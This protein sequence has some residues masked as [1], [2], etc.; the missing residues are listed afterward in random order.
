[1][2]LLLTLVILILSIGI[3]SANEDIGLDSL[4]DNSDIIPGLI[5]PDLD[6]DSNDDGIISPN[7]DSGKNNAFINAENDDVLAD[8]DD[9][10][11]DDENTGYITPE[12]NDTEDNETSDPGK[13]Y[14]KTYIDITNNAFEIDEIGD[15]P[16]AYDL[17]DYGWVTP[18]K[19]QSSSGSCWA[20]ASTAALESFL[21]KTEGVEYDFS[22]NNMKNIMGSYSVNGTDYGPNDGGNEVLILAYFTRWDGAIN[23]TDDPYNP[24][25][26]RSPYNL[27]RVKYVQDVLYVPKRTS[28]TDNDQIKM[29]LMTYG[30]LYTGIY[31]DS[32]YEKGE[33]YYYYGT[34]P[35]GNHAICIVG[36]DDTYSASNFRYK[37]QG[38]GAFIIKNSW[39]VV[40][41]Y[42]YEVGKEGYYY[43]S[44]YDSVF[45]GRGSNE[46]FS[47]MAFTN[48]EETT[49]YKQNYYYDVLGNTFDAVGYKNDTAWFANQFT[50][51]SNNPLKAV[52]FYTYG[53]STYSTYIYVNNSLKY[54]QSGSIKGA[55]Y[56]TVKLNQMVSLLA[57]DTFRIAVKLTT[58]NCNYPV[59][60]E[61]YHSGFTSNAKASA[62]QS[63]VS[64]NGKAWQDLTTV[65]GFSRANVCLKAYTGYAANIQLTS[66]SNV[67]FYSNGDEIELILNLTNIGDSSSV[68]VTAN[69]DSNVKIVSYETSSGTFDANTK[70]WSIEEVDPNVPNILRLIV[71]I[72]TKQENITNSF[73]ISSS[74]F[75]VNQNTSSLELFKRVNA[76]L[77]AQTLQTMYKSGELF[78]ATIVDEDEEAL[79]NVEVCFK[80]YNDKN[81]IVATYYNTTNDEG[82]VFLATDL[83]AGSYSVRISLVNPYYEGELVESIVVSKAN[84]MVTAINN[85]AILN[86]TTLISANVAS[87]D[88]IINEG[89]VTFYVNGVKIGSGDVVNGSATVEYKHPKV[90]NFEIN[91]VYS[92]SENYLE[93]NN[94]ASLDVDKITANFESKN[95]I[96]TYKDIDSYNVVVLDDEFNSV[97]KINI[98]FNIYKDGNLLANNYVIS[99]SEG[100]AKLSIDLSAGDYIIETN[101]VDDEYQGSINNTLN[102]TKAIAKLTASQNGDLYQNTSITISLKQAIT[103]KAYENQKVLVSFSNGKIYSLTTDSNGEASQDLD[104]D[105]G[106][107]T[108]QLNSANSNINAKS[109][110]S[111]VIKKLTANLDGTL[112]KDTF[113]NVEIVSSLKDSNN[114]GLKDKQI[115]III[116]GNTYTQ[117]TDEEGN[118]AFNL[119]LD[120]GTYSATIKS[121]DKNYNIDEKT[122]EVIIPKENAEISANDIINTYPSDTEIAA[123]LKDS[124]Q[125]PIANK[126]V[127]LLVNNKEYSQTTS[128]EGTVSF[129]VS[130][131]V[132]NYIA[133]FR[134]E[135]KNYNIPE[136]S[137]NIEIQS[138]PAEGNQSNPTENNTQP[139]EGNQSNPTE[140]NQTENGD[141]E[142][143]FA[144]IKANNIIKE[145]PENVEITTRL[146]NSRNRGIADT[147]IILTINNKEYS[148]ITNNRGYATFELDLGIGNYTAT[149]KSQHKNYNIEDKTIDIEFKAQTVKINAPN[150]VKYY[151]N[152]TQLTVNLVDKNNNPI[153]N[154]TILLTQNGVTYSRTSKEDGSAVLNIKNKPGNFTV[155]IKVN[156]TNY[157]GETSVNVTVLPM[158]TKIVAKNIV[159]YYKNNTQLSITLKDG[160]G[161]VL[162]NQKVS[163]K[164]SGKTYTK[165]TD[166]KGVATLK[167]NSK[168]G[169]YNVKISYSKSGYKS[170][171]KT[172][173]V[174]VIQPKISLLSSTVKKGKYLTVI[175]KDANGKVI[176]N[177]KVTVKIGSKTYTRTTNSQGRV[178]IKITLKKGKYTVNAKFASTALYG[179]T[180]KTYKFTVK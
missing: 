16:I 24:S 67:S 131:D 83:N 72:N 31:W 55:G 174:K 11:D 127:T 135:D 46:Y 61:T 91:A 49:Y 145:Y 180:A 149:L 42:G 52:G 43:V 130:L 56:H 106:E 148:Q 176:K 44:Y 38:D 73:I 50:A 27:T 39:G 9:G 84:T 87:D 10:D 29:A 172:V 60:I 40:D 70:I 94:K 157:A 18:I 175:F 15:L 129:N 30:A 177:K 89:N 77:S 2:I 110:G 125:N 74:L 138:Q 142:K 57:G 71:Q 14:S 113:N 161:K 150:V 160:E 93:S 35:Y 164:I 98:Q 171:T 155:Y 17:R 4:D 103:N 169:S 141:A 118:A 19:D 116:N 32:S 95:I 12:L 168:A 88:R 143:Q 76:Q 58:P 178:L 33:S 146:V 153:A 147:P 167:I 25:S 78:N 48:V 5:Y 120:A 68:D 1:M 47:A 123:T 114:N 122:L 156:D 86:R 13:L 163:F 3:A 102:I 90:G 62:N 151:L 139:A 26:T 36:W 132:G 92:E 165:T 158:P 115:S 37:P 162:A 137:I 85:N 51:T 117:T 134:C 107:Y 34:Y 23:E 124:N 59:A 101:I 8:G 121:E 100:N 173:T 128:Q 7:D 152:N 154:K 104:F 41:S 69:L 64:S 81:K 112:S 111:L 166:S 6:T 75:N 159:K 82:V 21:L 109:A 108:Y 65:S 22:E 140:G 105:A 28:P 126:A 170:V 79:S 133:S 119:D 99:D 63:F 136:K 97:G 45:A 54:S 20:F 144:E 80:I 179:A 53:S 96:S 66:T